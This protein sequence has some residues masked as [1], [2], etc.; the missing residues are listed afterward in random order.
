VP[1]Q[2]WDVEW[3]NSNSQRNYPLADDASCKDLTGTFELPTDF[4]VGLVLPVR[5]EADTDPGRFFLRRVTTSAAAST[6][7][8]SRMPPSS[9]TPVDVASVVVPVA[10]HTPGK[11]YA[12]GGV[13][14][15]EDTFGWAAVGPLQ[16]ILAQPAGRWDFDLAAARLDPDAVRLQLRGVSGIVVAN[17]DQRSPVLRGVVTLQAGANARITYGGAAGGN[18]L[19]LSFVGGENDQTA[20]DC[21]CGPGATGVPV[22]RIQG[23]VPTPS[24]D[25]TLIGDECIRFEPIANG[26]RV[27]DICSKPC[28]SCP[29]LEAVTRDLDRLLAEARTVQD[30]ANRLQTSVTTTDLV[31]L[32]SRLADRSSCATG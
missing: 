10:G 26:L 2:V 20:A 9:S 5:A 1:L 24:G 23:V 14:P 4:L 22:R 27:I 21:L 7:L 29:E 6:L 18:T 30:M 31:V 28:C 19:E 15:Y 12:V 8:F 13:T 32:S 3:E 25:F 11:I 16:N 17:G